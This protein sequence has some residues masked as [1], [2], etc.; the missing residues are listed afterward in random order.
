MLKDYVGHPLQTRGAEQYILQNGKGDGM[1]FVYVRNGIGLEMW[2]SVDRCADVSR[3]TVNGNNIAFFS[4]C[5]YVAPSYY[6]HVKAGFL[7]SF[8]AGLI[9]TCG[10]T[11]CGQPCTDDGEE[12][13]LHGTVANL[14]AELRCI[15][16]NEDGLTLKF[17]IRDSVIFGRKLVLT[18]TYN[19]SYAE[20]KFTM[21]DSVIND[22]DKESP[23]MLMYHCNLGYPLL[24]E[25]SILKIPNNSYYAHSEEAKK[26]IDTA[27]ILEKPQEQ[28]IERCYFYDMTDKNGIVKTGLY[29][30]DIDTALVISYNKKQ[31]PYLTEW[32][33]MGKTDYVLGLE[34]GNCTPKGRNV[35]REEGTLMFLK[36]NETYDASLT[37]SFIKGRDKFE[38][39]F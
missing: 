26:H 28:Y 14:P 9:T 17:V 16:E 25:N 36:P 21:S 19:I 29:N 33:M 13:P 1:H 20:N 3:L 35:L 7:K 23:I 31:L 6:D 30:P 18:R 24:S 5:G 32:K 2:I 10:L 39:E 15:D 4:P 38:G 22:A 11:A 12:L 8:T 34:H 37:F 27:L